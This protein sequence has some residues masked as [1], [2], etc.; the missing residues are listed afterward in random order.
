[1]TADTVL[2]VTASYDQSAQPVLDHLHSMGASVFRLDTDQFPTKV[3]AHFDP[4]HGLA[5]KHSGN[6][7]HG[8]QVKSVWYRRNVAPTLP[9]H[10]DRYN[11]EFCTRESRA[12]LD[13]A[14]AS[15]PTDRWLSQPM[16]ISRA[17]LKLYQL[18]VANQIGFRLP[19]TAATNDEVVVMRFTENRKTVSKAVR[20]GYIDSPEGYRS[21]FTTALSEEDL[22]DLGGLCL[23]PVTFQEHIPKKS[24]IRVTVVGEEVFA[25]EIMSQSHP[26]SATDWRATENPD[27]EHKI[28]R[29]PDSTKK[30]CLELVQ[31]LGLGFGAIDL[32]LTE[33]DEYV[34]FEINPNGE[35]LWIELQLGFPIAKRIAQWLINQEPG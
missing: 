18:T 11:Q 20:S 35:W 15:I 25:A 30:R 13:G 34:F 3:K 9:P 8:D 26:S 19:A 16:A 1:M 7:I 10:L 31:H 28:H 17:E 12:F 5:L 27:L 32:A 14:L 6:W 33:G 4:L 24:D 21:M 23:A 2:L 29:L 22:H